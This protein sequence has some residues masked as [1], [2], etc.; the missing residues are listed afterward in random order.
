MRDSYGFYDEC[1]R[2]ANIK[3]WKAF[4]N[5][6][7]TMPV[8]AVVGERILCI[9]G[10]LSPHLRNFDQIRTLKRPMD[11]PDEGLVCDLLWSDPDGSVQGWS[12]NYR[13]V[14]YV[15]GHD[16]ISTFQRAFG[17]DLIC[18][19]HQVRVHRIRRRK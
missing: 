16:V 6:F 4:V 1:K 7:N 3:T 2:R 10:G 5:A 12:E 9:H 17:I 11:I 8:A 13:G 14:S 18:R 15:F 19:A